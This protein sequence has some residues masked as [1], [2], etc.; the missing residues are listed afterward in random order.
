VL[1]VAVISAGLWIAYSV[2]GGLFGVAVVAAALLSMA[3]IVVAVDSYGRI[4]DN[5]GG[6]AE[7]SE[8]PP[9]VRT[10]TDTLDAMLVGVVAV[11]MGVVMVLLFRLLLVHLVTFFPLPLA[12]IGAFVALAVTGHATNIIT[13]LAISLQAAVLPA[14]VITAGMWIA[15]SVGDGTYGVALAAAARRRGCPRC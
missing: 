12:I 11:R 1:P 15:Y 5:A 6:I 13:G 10:I 4:T 8:L 2:G 7:V 3:G 14:T 9:D